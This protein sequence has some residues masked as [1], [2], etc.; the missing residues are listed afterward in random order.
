M[1]R[2]FLL[3]LVLH[4]GLVGFLYSWLTLAR[5]LAVERG[6]VA[7]DAFQSAGG[8]PPSV[9]PI[10]RNLANQFELPT[11]AWFCA[12]ILVWAGALG[13]ADVVAAWIFLIGR[14]IHTGVQ[15]LTSNVPLRGM[16][17][18]INAL[19]VAWLAA[20]VASLLLAGG[21]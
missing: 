8:D 12:A 21:A 5:R 17:F 15:T 6:E 19:G 11:L 10:A 18:L 16:V 14:I 4:F 3:P 7:Y 9:E 20:H 13:T 1:V 2:A